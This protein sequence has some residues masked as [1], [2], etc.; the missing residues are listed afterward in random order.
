M[1]RTPGG[2]QVLVVQ[3]DGG[4]DAGASLP[5]L[6]PLETPAAVALEEGGEGNGLE[7]WQV[8]TGTDI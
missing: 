1:V 7:S 8:S 3:R 2:R 6:R 4:P 5:S